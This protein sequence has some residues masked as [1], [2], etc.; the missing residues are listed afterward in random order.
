LFL[1]T[2]FTAKDAKGRRNK[3]LPL[4]TLITG[5]FTEAETRFFFFDFAVDLVARGVAGFH[6]Q[7]G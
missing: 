3:T 7:S 1:G 6:A 5:I 2:I 4:M